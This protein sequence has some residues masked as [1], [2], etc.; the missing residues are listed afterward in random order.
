MGNHLR[1]ETASQGPGAQKLGPGKLLE[2]SS[3]WVLRQTEGFKALGWGVCGKTRTGAQVLSLKDPPLPPPEKPLSP[4]WTEELT[5]RG[6]SSGPALLASL[7]RAH[8][9]SSACLPGA[10]APG[11]A[12]WSGCPPQLGRAPPTPLTLDSRHSLLPHTTDTGTTHPSGQG[13]TSHGTKYT[14]QR[15]HGRTDVAEPGD[16]GAG[17][18]LG[19]PGCSPPALRTQ[20]GALSPTTP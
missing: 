8:L 19:V 5:Y 14:S 10:Q 18:H 12:P 9:L 7:S 16:R 2:V 6:S 4:T 11:L 15:Q 17:V 3:H 20:A 1:S 13:F